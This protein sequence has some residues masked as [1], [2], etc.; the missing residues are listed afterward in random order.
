LAQSLEQTLEEAFRDELGLPKLES[1]REY[2]STD[3]DRPILCDTEDLS[4]PEADPAKSS[5]GIVCP[6]RLIE[7]AP[8]VDVY[9]RP[10]LP[11]ALREQTEMGWRVSGWGAA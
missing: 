8:F 6:P 11:R 10:P 7:P 9:D 4:C 2:S 1:D 5:P 3:S